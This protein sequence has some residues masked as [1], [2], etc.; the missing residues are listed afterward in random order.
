MK[1]VNKK[2]YFQN[3]ENRNLQKKKDL[4]QFQNIKS[5]T[6]K[7]VWVR[8]DGLKCLVI[9]MALRVG[10]ISRWY[11]DSGCSRD[12]TGNR[13]LF[14]NLEETQSGSVTFGDR[15]VA[16]I[17]V[18]GTIEILGIPTLTNVLFVQGLKH[19]IICISQICVKGYSVRFVKD[20]SEIKDNRSDEILIKGL[21]INDNCCHR[22]QQ[23]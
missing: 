4:A 6:F 12:M 22:T 10:S 19:N 1:N 23:A 20:G 7:K 9:Q 8:K 15:N 21:R 2:N 11:L 3:F 14:V 17:I 13:S 16:K 18:K 5:K